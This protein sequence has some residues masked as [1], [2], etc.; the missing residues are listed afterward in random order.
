MSWSFEAKGNPPAVLTAIQ[1]STGLKYKC[2]E[3]EETI[4]QKVIEIFTTALEAMPIDHPIHVQAYGSQD[5]SKI[6]VS[7]NLTVSIAP[8]WHFL[9]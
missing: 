4:K 2:L 1:E 8:M 5:G 7:N 9:K 3:P 6:P